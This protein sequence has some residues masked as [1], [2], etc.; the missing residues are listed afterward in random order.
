[1]QT[2]KMFEKK[3]KINLLSKKFLSFFTQQSNISPQWFTAWSRLKG[4]PG[5]WA[6]MYNGGSSSQHGLPS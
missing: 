4:V 2:K 6:A 3:H 5:C 1:M